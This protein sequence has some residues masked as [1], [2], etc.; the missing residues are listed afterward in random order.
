MNK[1]WFSCLI[2]FIIDTLTKQFAWRQ[3]TPHGMSYP[4]DQESFYKFVIVKNE[5]LM[6][7]FLSENQAFVVFIMAFAV[8]SL[9]NFLKEE[10]FL[11][12]KTYLIIPAGL[13]LGGALGNLVDRMTR[14]FVIDFISIGEW[15]VFNIADAAVVTG[16]ILMIIPENLRNDRS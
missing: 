6:L 1:L 15:P 4:L 2:T 7:G 9:Y 3:F 11:T 13:I 14:G 8:H 12:K 16:I 5:G 10:E